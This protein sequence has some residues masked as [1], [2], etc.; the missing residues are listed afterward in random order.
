MTRTGRPRKA[1][2]TRLYDKVRVGDGC[3]EWTG[4]TSPT[5]YGHLP[6][7]TTVN[8]PREVLAHRFVYELL[9]GPIPDGLDIDHLCRNRACVRPSHLE[10]V[11]PRENILRGEGPSAHNARQTHCARGH[12]FTA[13]NTRVHAGRRYC[14]ACGR[15]RMR[16]QRAHKKESVA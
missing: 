13:A 12:E 2:I 6:V 3:W 9:V 14:R 7:R 8:E 5:G 16:Q 15:E 1:P 11:P 4:A 10:P